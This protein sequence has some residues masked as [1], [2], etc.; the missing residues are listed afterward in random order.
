[1]NQTLTSS[2]AAPAKLIEQPLVQVV[3]PSP[4]RVLQIE[5]SIIAFVDPVRSR[6]QFEDGYFYPTPKKVKSS[7]SVLILNSL[8]L[9]LR[10]H[11][12]LLRQ[13]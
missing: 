12:R 8:Q 13:S 1:M 11:S 4:V 5:F 2:A 7:A 3:K 10:Q 9:P 6:Q